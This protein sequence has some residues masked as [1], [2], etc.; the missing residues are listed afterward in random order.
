MGRV[1][2]S[3]SLLSWWTAVLQLGSG[4]RQSG[5]NF[6][7]LLV[8]HDQLVNSIILLDGGICQVVKQH[9]HLLCL[10]VQANVGQK[11]VKSNIL[12]VFF[13]V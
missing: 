2:T 6:C 3:C 5:D 10:V 12:Q 4:C 8:C 13:V 9:L 1:L 7:L 11:L